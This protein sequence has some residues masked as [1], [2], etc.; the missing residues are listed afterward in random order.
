MDYNFT[1]D[2]ANLP[3]NSTNYTSAVVV[4]SDGQV[5][6]AALADL[7]AALLVSVFCQFVVMVVMLV[8]YLRLSSVISRLP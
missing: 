1:L 2:Y 4:V 8:L 3:F 7:H 6:Q 5:Y